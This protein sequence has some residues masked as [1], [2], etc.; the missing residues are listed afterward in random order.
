MTGI[1]IL[2]EGSG[3]PVLFLHGNPDTSDLWKPIIGEL[4]DAFRCIAPDL[5]GFGDSEAPDDFDCSLPSMVKFVDDVLQQEGVTGPCGLVVHDFGGPFGLAWAVK[6]PDRVSRIC[7]INTNF[8][9]D[10]RWHIWAKVWRTPLLGELSLAT[11]TWPLFRNALKKGSRLLS[12]ADMRHAYSRLTPGMKKMTLRL[13]RATDPENFRGWEDRL[14]EV[15]AKVPTLVLWGDQD[16]YISKR[17]AE[18]YGAKKVVHFPDSGH[19]VPLEKRAEAA[20]IL[21]EFLS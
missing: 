20:A 10:F 19:W 17:F 15:T 4:R 5:P 16:P 6:N 7:V 8:F 3:S 2:E 11:M 18:R 14:L 1:H 12:E 21:R 13:Y 9:S